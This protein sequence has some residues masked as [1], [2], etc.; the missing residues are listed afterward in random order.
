MH[1]PARLAHL[2]ARRRFATAIC[3]LRRSLWM[4]SSVQQRPR[5]R[6]LHSPR[7]PRRP[8][9]FEFRTRRAVHYTPERDAWWGW[10]RPARIWLR[11]AIA[12]WRPRIPRGN[13]HHVAPI[14]R[15]LSTEHLET[16][17]VYE[18]ARSPI[19]ARLPARSRR[20]PRSA[21]CGSAP[22]PISLSDRV[23]ATRL[24]NPARTAASLGT[25]GTR[26]RAGGAA[27]R[28]AKL[29]GRPRHSIP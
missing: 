8:I 19:H 28:S 16:T 3:H 7:H 29:G 9:E 6:R 4:V 5:Q 17:Y 23:P 27:W 25:D 1:A 24:S 12:L 26:R 10:R 13:V 21:D 2:G 20:S 18:L 11:P 15:S 22:A 14:P